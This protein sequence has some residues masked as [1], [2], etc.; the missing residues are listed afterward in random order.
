VAQKTSETL[1]YRRKNDLS[2]TTAYAT[3]QSC[4]RLAA[5]LDLPLSEAAR[6][7]VPIAATAAESVERLRAWASG[8]CLDASRPGIFNRGSEPAPM[9]RRVSRATNN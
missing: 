4:C 9:P 3:E 7:V 1:K 8:R 5:L 2:H 6:N